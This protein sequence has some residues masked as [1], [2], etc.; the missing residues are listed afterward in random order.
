MRTAS[1]RVRYA[2]L[3]QTVHAAPTLPFE[4]RLD[5]ASEVARLNDL[6]Y[7]IEELRLA[8]IGSGRG[9]VRLHTVVAARRHRA[10]ELKRLTGLQ[11]GEGQARVLLDDLRSHGC[12]GPSRSEQDVARS[13]LEAVLHPA[14]AR[15]RAALPGP[16]DVVQSYCDLLEVRWLLSER[17]GRDVGTEAA[18][19]VLAAGRIPAGAAAQ[20]HSHAVDGLRWD[21][22]RLEE[23]QRTA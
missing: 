19:Q 1:V 13:W 9:E 5:A 16:R 8:S 7:S 22:P 10:D 18:V 23:H 11:V 3:W 20:L 21:D 14:V 12:V 4:E 17:A 15:L 2:A 6:G